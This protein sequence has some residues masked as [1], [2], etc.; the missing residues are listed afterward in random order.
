MHEKRGEKRFNENILLQNSFDNRKRFSVNVQEI[1]N[2]PD[3][4]INRHSNR[5]MNFNNFNIEENG[6]DIVKV[7]DS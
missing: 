6:K 4:E 1:V 2:T 7:A 5:E 3:T